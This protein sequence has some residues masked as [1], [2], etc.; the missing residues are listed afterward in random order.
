MSY[1]PELQKVIDQLNLKKENILY[2]TI[3]NVYLDEMREQLKNVEYRDNT[4]FFRRKLFIKGKDGLPSHEMKPLKYIL[5]QGGYEPNSPRLLIGLKGWTL[6]KK[7]FPDTLDIQ[8]HDIYK[9]ICLLLDTIVF[10]SQRGRLYR[11]IHNLKKPEKVM[12]KVPDKSVLPKKESVKK[13]MKKH[14]LI[15]EI[16]KRKKNI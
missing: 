5:F 14:K 8:G 3:K 6:D 15:L 16:R 9:G 2:L 10:D 7:K 4:E 12:A 11:D 13:G 1:T